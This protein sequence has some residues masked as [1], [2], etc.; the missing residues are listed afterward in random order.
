MIKKRKEGKQMFNLKIKQ[1][2]DP[3][4]EE[5]NSPISSSES[6]MAFHK[7]SLTFF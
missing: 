7:Q 5:T 6:Q 4:Y 2:F 3:P 1:R